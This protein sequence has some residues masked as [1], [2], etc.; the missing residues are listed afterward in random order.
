MG[1]D[2]MS[3]EA[4]TE[5]RTDTVDAWRF[6]ALAGLM[7]RDQGQL[8]TAPPLAHWLMFRAPVCQSELGADGHPQLSGVLAPYSGMRRM[9]ASSDVTFLAPIPI[10]VPCVLQSRIAS[11]EEKQGRSGRLVFTTRAHEVTCAGQLCVRETQN[12]VY[13]PPSPGGTDASEAAEQG[14]WQRTL[15]PDITMLMRYSA[16]TYNA[17]RIHYDRDYSTGEEGYPGLV[18]HG[19]LA[20]TLLLDLYRHRCPNRRVSSFG[21]RARRPLF[22]GRSLV[23]HGRPT[24][25]GAAMWIADEDGRLAMTASVESGETT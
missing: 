24:D 3:S 25:T 18:V 17:H 7:D 10:G 4:D 13:R 22:E 6:V 20:A 21:F 16:L 11:V 19:P 14:A 2:S 8:I 1:Q 5:I 12:V 9:W 15:R 23:L